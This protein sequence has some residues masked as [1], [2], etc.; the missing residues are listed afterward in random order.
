MGFHL[1]TFLFLSFLMGQAYGGG[2]KASLAKMPVVAESENKG[3]L[4]DLVKAIS[5]QG[6]PIEY[7]VVPF[8]RSM[9]SVINGDVDFHLPLIKMPDNI[10]KNLD[11]DF[12]TETIYKI[13]FVL[14]SNKNKKIDM[15]NLGKY[16]LE[17]DLA[18]VG[19]FDFKISGSTDI[20]GS[21][22]NVDLG[23]IDGFIF[24]DAAADPL[25]KEK[26]FKNIARTFYKRYDVKIILPKG[27]RGGEA[28][29]ML[30][31]AIAKLKKSGKYAKIMSTID[32]PYEDWQP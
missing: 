25:L 13:N 8:N 21:L 31:K 18:H 27:K 2:F 28:D 10:A 17:T 19:Y 6:S 29:Q 12:S 23:R 3:V 26:K 32:K 20:A 9:S 22:R 30:S 16:K 4:V 11:F 7:Q 14:Y 1:F 5:S 24:A 15:N